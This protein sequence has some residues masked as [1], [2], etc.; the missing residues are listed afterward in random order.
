MEAINTSLFSIS[1][2][3][4]VGELK[5]QSCE[6]ANIFYSQHIHND[7]NIGNGDY[8]PKAMWQP[9]VYTHQMKMNEDVV[10]V[11]GDSTIIQGLYRDRYGKGGE[12]IVQ[13]VLTLYI[14]IETE[15]PETKGG[16][17]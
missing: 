4:L 15:E 10:A 12:K 16:D 8:S 13:Y 6:E 3:E 7:K 2:N 9:E 17:K 5:L 11:D 14:W 1:R